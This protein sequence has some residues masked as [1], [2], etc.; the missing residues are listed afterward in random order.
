MP[1]TTADPLLR[2]KLGARSCQWAGRS[3]PPLSKSPAVCCEREELSL[4][5]GCHVLLE[6]LPGTVPHP[7]SIMENVLPEDVC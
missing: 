1:S 3:L 4:V 7:G 5:S 2:L 6:G